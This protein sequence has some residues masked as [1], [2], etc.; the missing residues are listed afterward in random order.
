MSERVGVLDWILRAVVCGFRASRDSLGKRPLPAGP[1]L[2]PVEIPQ[3]IVDAMDRGALTVEQLRTLVFVEA[4]AIGLTFEGAVS[5]WRDG[6]L[7]RCL[8]GD[9]LDMLIFMLEGTKQ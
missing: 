7:S 3:E 1:S 9:D 6:T 4:A 2:W 8:I 5:A